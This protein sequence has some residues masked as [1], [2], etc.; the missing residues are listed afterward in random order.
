[1]KRESSWVELC[2]VWSTERARWCYSLACF[3]VDIIVICLACPLRGW[4]S[5]VWGPTAGNTDCLPHNHQGHF[6]RRVIS[7]EKPA[8]SWALLVQEAAR[9]LSP[10]D[11]WSVSPLGLT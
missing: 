3:I 7:L 2:R 4:T 9:C 10:K 6:L 5:S 8:Q 1:M 11:W